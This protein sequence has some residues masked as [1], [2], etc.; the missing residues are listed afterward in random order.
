MTTIYKVF[1]GNVANVLLTADHGFLYNDMKFEEKDKHSIKESAIEKKT[2]YYLTDS[3][4]GFEDIV[5]FPLDKV[6]SIKSTTPLQVAVPIG[7]NRLAAPGGYNFAHG[8]AS[9]QE[10][11]IPVIRSQQKRTNKTEKVG[12]ALMNHN[13][14]M[15]SSR[16]KFQMIQSE[17]VSI[18]VMERKVVCCIYN[19]DAPVTQEKEVTLNST[20]ATN[21]NNRVFEVTL[22]LNKSVYASMLQLRIY[23]V[24][25]KLNPLVRETVKNNTMIEQDF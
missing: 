15:V 4:D 21:L 16:L 5:K 25:D 20:D 6:S 18:T 12:V 7:T 11:I 3:N 8:G 10:M 24:D 9:L 14:N 13:L 17:A 19:G 22:N 2:R 1:N 23:D